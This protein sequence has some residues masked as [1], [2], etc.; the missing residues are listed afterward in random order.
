MKRFLALMTLLGLS[1][2]IGTGQ[3]TDIQAKGEGKIPAMTGIDLLG[4]DRPIPDSFK[5]ELNIVTFAFEREQQANVDTWIPSAEAL[6][7]EIDGLDF[8]E[9]P[10]IYEMNPVMR[11]WVNNGMRSGIPGERARERTITV[12][13]DRDEFLNMMDMT[14]ET[15]YT[16]LVNREGSILWREEGDMTD[17]KLAS[18][19]QAIADN[20]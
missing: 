20:L 9:I 13:T 8:Y 2:C 4:E 14:T 3:N 6:V 19:K 5:G 17:E 10:L 7:D 15:I 16:L 1:A 12:Y 11:G 18:L